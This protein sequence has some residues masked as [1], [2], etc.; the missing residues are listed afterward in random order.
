MGI[1]TAVTRSVQKYT[2]IKKWNLYSPFTL[3]GEENMD[4]AEW[5]WEELYLKAF[6]ETNALNL[7]GRIGDAEKA[8]ASRT[9]ELRTIADG[10]LE[11]QAIENA[12]NGLS[13][14]KREIRVPLGIHAIGRLPL[15]NSWENTWNGSPLN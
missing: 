13:I 11:W 14:L 8:I 6:L 4:N 5:K 15:S 7:P 10:E 12:M 9:T 1:Q 3:Q 2:D